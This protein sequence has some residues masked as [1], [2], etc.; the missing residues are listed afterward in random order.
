MSELIKKFKCGSILEFDQGRFDGWCIY[1]TAPGSP[2]MAIKDIEIFGELE[3]IGWRVG[4]LKLYQEFCYIYLRTN[5]L[6]SAK[7]VAEISDLS[8]K[9]GAVSERVDYLLTCLYA[10]MVAEENKAGAVLRKRVKRLGVHQ[11]LV[12]ERPPSY[13]AN[14]SR[15]KPSQE[16]MIECEVRGF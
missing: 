9:Y 2:R 15:G 16:L 1:H 13:A 5:S 10:G 7:I 6:L 14:F 11:L 8:L 3:L 12:E 4:A